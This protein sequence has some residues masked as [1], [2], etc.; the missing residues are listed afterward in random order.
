MYMQRKEYDK[1]LL[2]SG[3][4]LF[5]SGAVYFHE[6][7]GREILNAGTRCIFV[8]LPSLYL[9][10]VLAAFC[11]KSGFLELLSEILQKVLKFNSV[12]LVVL[13]SQIGGYPVGAQLLHSMYQEGR[14]SQEQEENLLCS[15]MGCGFGFLFAIVGGNMRV[16]LVLWLVITMPNLLLAGFFLRSVPEVRKNKMTERKTFS[17]LLTESVENAAA[18]MLKICGMILA[19]GACMGILNGLTGKLNQIIASIL[20]ISNVSEYMRNGGTLPVVAGLLSFGGLCVHFQIAAICENHIC[21]M[22]FLLCRIFTAVSAGLLC[23]FCLPYLV[24][25]SVPVFL[26]VPLTP[27]Y[28]TEN[29]VPACCLAVMSVFVLKKY[30]FFRKSLTNSE[31]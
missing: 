16:A 1:F 31:K 30:D 26:T 5:F 21:W 28:S 29:A 18:A 4:L 15:C 11:V 10:S 9:F 14:I 23:R 2:L 24:P 8:I 27:A 25:E 13:F 6:A 3:M 19:F 20:E 22:K 17:V 12:W 7:V